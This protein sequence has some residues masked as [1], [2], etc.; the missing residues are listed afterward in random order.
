MEENIATAR[1]LLDVLRDAIETN[2]TE[3]AKR[4]LLLLLDAVELGPGRP[5]PLPL[6]LLLHA[7]SAVT[8]TPAR[9]RRRESTRSF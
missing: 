9:K 2:V 1:L 4:R 7:A 6:L 8:P 3:R 5:P